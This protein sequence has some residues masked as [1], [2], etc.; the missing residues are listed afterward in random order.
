[1]GEVLVEDLGEVLVEVDSVE[2]VLEV[3]GKI[4]TIKVNTVILLNSMLRL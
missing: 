4:E 1:M 3:A 2:V